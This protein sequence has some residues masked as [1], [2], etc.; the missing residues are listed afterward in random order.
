[1]K[2]WIAILFAAIIS[3]VLAG[4]PTYA[5]DAPENPTNGAVENELSKN[6]LVTNIV[7]EVENRPA[8]VELQKEN[9]APIASTLVKCFAFIETFN[10]GN[11]DCKTRNEFQGYVWTND[12]WRGGRCAQASIYNTRGENNNNQYFYGNSHG[13]IHRWIKA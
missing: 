4:Q 7:F 9:S 8:A 13:P 10:Y 11:T 5:A 3:V 2:A 12:N 6:T 1:V